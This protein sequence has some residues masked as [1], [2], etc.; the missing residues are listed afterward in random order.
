MSPPS[1]T[2][3]LSL[4]LVWKSP[5]L[6][7]RLFTPGFVSFTFIEQ[8]IWVFFFFKVRVY[9]N[10]CALV[11]VWMRT[12]RLDDNLRCC[13]P[14]PTSLY[15][16]HHC[17]CWASWSHELLG[18]L[19]P[20]LPNRVLGLQACVTVLAFMWVFALCGRCLVH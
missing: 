4:Y 3:L 14:L 20:Q 8:T 9:L 6:L 18:I 12:W 19:L 13:T 1:S 15:R 16:S 2:S 7:Q 10:L 11:S 17:K 5:F